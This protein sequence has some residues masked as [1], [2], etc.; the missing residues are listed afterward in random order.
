MA[1]TGYG[2]L[3]FREQ[4]AFFRAK[5]GVL[6]ESYLDVFGAEHDISFMVAGANRADLLADLRAAI[7]R[8]IADG[9]TLED[10]RREF[11]GIVAR[12]GWDYTGGRNW[13]TRVIYETNLRQSYN[14]GRWQ[15]LQALKRVRPY[16]R[17][18]H[19]D[20]VEHPR[21]IHQGWDG[22]VLDADDPWFHTHFPANGYGC[23][24]YV[25]ALNAR[26]LRRLGKSGPDRAP[27]VEW[28]EVTI[29]QRSPGGPRQVRTPVG[30]DPGFGYAPGQSLDGWPRD[31]PPT[32]PSLRRPLERSAQ[33]ALDKM[34][35]LPA[36][37]GADSAAQ[38][39]A[40]PRA[41]AAL[42]AG[43]AEWQAAVLAT[44]KASNL[45][46]TVGALEPAVVQ[47]MRLAGLEP[48]TAI[49]LV[50]D[51]DVLHALRDRKTAARSGRA[52]GLTAA[53][54]AQLPAL[55]QGR[56]AVLL[57]AAA[58]ALLYIYD[59]V[60]REAG[61]VVVRVDYR[62]K[63]ADGKAQVNAFRT[64]SLIDLVDVRKDVAAGRLL[65]VAG[66]L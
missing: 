38:V 37:A 20:A 17:Y 13:R 16:W 15:Q 49:I 7:D 43:Y 31:A 24:C 50:R 25:E 40:L 11:D 64:A 29:G 8:V 53:E 54:L 5:R 66:A 36:A 57:D 4:I 63:T 28:H 41:Q 47:G 61:K 2:S 60:R 55:L 6:T 39:L 12:Y 9:A 56:R 21:P 46:Y 35:R 48:A 3:P 59:A 45:S 23:Q 26:D 52:V 51:A 42:Q 58:G 30:I 14:A 65:L 22:L 44:G 10:F 33:N 19:S 27:A 32:P 1:T 18:R 62:L 34:A